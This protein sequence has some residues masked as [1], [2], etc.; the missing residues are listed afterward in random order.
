MKLCYFN[1]FTLGVVKG[2]AVVDVSAVV[3]DIPHTGPHNL[4]NGLIERFSQY[5]GKLEKAAAEGKAIPLSPAELKQIT[6]EIESEDVSVDVLAA[7]VKRAAELAAFCQAKLRSTETEVNN[8]IQ[9]MEAAAKNPSGGGMAG[10]GMGAGMGV[11][12]PAQD[13]RRVS[14]GPGGRIPAVR[15]R[16]GRC[17]P[18]S[19]FSRTRVS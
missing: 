12:R 16:P 17:T 2:D 6:E 10:V 4:I 3:R 7:R 11:A 13:G 8:I 5:R 14:R 18:R 1:D 19:A 15:G 9:S